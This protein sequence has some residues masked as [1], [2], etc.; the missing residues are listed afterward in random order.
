VILSISKGFNR[1]AIEKKKKTRLPSEI[2]IPLEPFQ[3]SIWTSGQRKKE[4]L[5][6]SHLLAY[7]RFPFLRIKTPTIAMAMIMA[8]AANSVYVMT[9]ELIVPMLSGE[10]VGAGVLV[11]VGVAAGSTT[12]TVVAAEE[13]PYELSPA[14]EATKVYVSAFGGVQVVP[15]VPKYALEITVPMLTTLPF[16]ST[17][18]RVT[19]TPVIVM[20]WATPSIG[21][22]MCKYSICVAIEAED[23]HG[24]SGWAGDWSTTLPVITRLCPMVMAVNG[25][26]IVV[27]LKPFPKTYMYP[28]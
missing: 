27:L 28:S 3:P 20:L 26:S 2:S 12:P 10:G 15:N 22:C 19:G 4:G 11:G 25:A 6:G 5:F 24:V 8:I 9:E 1:Q 23:T 16:E 18:V 14:N 7:C 21:S 17:A 13:I